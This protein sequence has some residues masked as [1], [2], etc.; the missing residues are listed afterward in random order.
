[1]I[2]QDILNAQ[3]NIG[4]AYK[5]AE[6]KGLISDDYKYFIQ[7]DNFQFHS[8]VSNYEEN[9]NISNTAN[10]TENHDHDEL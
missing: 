2:S 7:K 5:L 8:D 6:R 10:I 1:M 3:S 9:H 4:Y